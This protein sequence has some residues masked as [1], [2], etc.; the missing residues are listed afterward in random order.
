MEI[1]SRH[2]FTLVLALVFT[3]L[4]FLI[5]LAVGFRS[6]SL[7]LVADS[8]HLLHRSLGR[9][10]HLA[11]DRM[12]LWS[13]RSNTYGWIRLE[14]TGVLVTAVLLIA[15]CFTVVAEALERLVHTHVM[16][17]PVIVMVVAGTGLL[18]KVV[19]LLSNEASQSSCHGNKQ[20]N[21]KS[22]VQMN[23][24]FTSRDTDL[25]EE[26]SQSDGPNTI[27]VILPQNPKQGPRRSTTNLLLQLLW[28]LVTSGLVVASA[29]V[30][31]V[32]EDGNFWV[33]P[34]LSVILATVFVCQA[35]PGS[36]Q[37]ALILLQATPQHLLTKD[38]KSQLQ[39][40]VAGVAGVH[41]LHVW[42]LST[43][44]V[45]ATAHIHCQDMVEWSETAQQIQAFFHSHGVHYITIQPE[46]TENGGEGVTHGC[47]LECGPD[48]PC[49]QFTCCHNRHLGKTT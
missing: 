48:E 14:V 47:M 31:Y 19:G 4:G 2:T 32:V 43:S 38:L 20:E 42:N 17:D 41:D 11:A 9:G 18:V 1:C 35:V 24:I 3:S 25:S 5:E 36:R 45:V 26:C 34:V 10:V 49:H 46:V 33:D 44:C 23:N 40:Q 8:Y 12:A 30:V 15:L 13:P 39:A 22:H 37:A 16:E 21:M 6:H 7:T 27:E 28:D 29:L